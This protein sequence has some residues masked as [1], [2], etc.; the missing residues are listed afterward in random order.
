MLPEILSFKLN[1]QSEIEK[2]RISIANERLQPKSYHYVKTFQH[3]LRR[4]EKGSKESSWRLAFCFRKEIGTEKN[5]IY[6]ECLSKKSNLKESYGGIF[7]FG[8]ILYSINYDQI[9]Y[10]LFQK[11][12]ERNLP[13]GQY[14]FG[15]C[16]FFGDGIEKNEK[17]G[18]Q[19]MKFAGESGDA[20]WAKKLALH[21]KNGMFG[22]SKT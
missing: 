3:Y 9:A 7:W 5:I 2:I 14:W 6:A 15:F 4:S 11:L 10:F 1:S 19:L 16:R 18:I 22:F 8:A 13:S 12:A 21:L 20:Y 17:E